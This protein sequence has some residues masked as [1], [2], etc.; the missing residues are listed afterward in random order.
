M[1]L[2]KLLKYSMISIVV[3][4]IVYANEPQKLDTLT[5]TANKVEENLQ[6]VPQ[7]ITVLDVEEIN[8]KGIKTVEDIIAEIPNMT[9]SPDRGVKVNFRGLNASLFTENNPV[10]IYIDG[11]P[12]SHKYDFTASLQNAKR[13]E[14]LRGPQ[15]TLYG[16]DSIGGVINIVTKEPTNQT[17]GSVGLE[18][19]SN[20]YRRGTFNINTPIVENK[21][22][23]NLNGELTV[24][25]GWVTNT[26]K[27][28]DKAAKEDDKKLSASFYYKATDKL[29]T[30]LVL[31]SERNK[32]YGYKG[33]G[34][35]G[36]SGLNLFTRDKA[37]NI[38]LE[39]PMV[40][41]NKIDSQ[42]LSFKYEA[43]NYNF[44]SVTVHRK[45]DLDAIFDM[46]FTS[47]TVYDGTNGFNDAQ[48]DSYSQ[49]FRLSNKN[50]ET[51]RW[52]A[53]LYADT[54]ESKKNA[55]GRNTVFMG[56]S[57]GTLNSV[58]TIDSDTQAIFGQIMVP[59]DEKM[60]LTL[61]GR[62]QKI[63]KDINL[64]TTETASSLDVLLNSEKTWNTFL[65]KIALNYK[66][67]ENL[68]SFV[69]ISKGYLPGGFNLQATNS[70]KDDNLFKPQQS[71]NYEVG[72]KTVVDNFTFTAS[73]FRMNIKDIHV[74]RTN[75]LA[76]AFTDNADKAHSQGIEFDFR[77][78]PTD[79]LEISG[80]V[81]F[82]DAKYD[83]YNEGTTKLD[84][85]KIETTPSH[86][87]SLGIAYY[88]PTGV[89][90]R[91]DIRNQGSTH[92][93]DGKEKAFLKRD[94]FT[95]VDAKV[96]YKFSDWDIYTYVKNLTDEKYINTYESNSLFSYASF[97]APRFIGIGVKY[98]F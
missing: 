93:Y 26:V 36:S 89:Y 30:R 84:G 11:I 49:E 65:P 46:D 76:Q 31:K 94:S 74:I 38:R 55:Y 32:E 98:T 6:D 21:L 18:Y 57:A 82:V 70:N 9:T 10:V 87:A 45:T 53:G 42:S 41:K 2:Q 72:V 54:E 44:E 83:S 79:S 20:N 68:T 85:N 58:S 23:F 19:G 96:G 80:A 1:K 16:K 90:A 91:T 95:L 92:F 73:V 78:F 17:S 50:R 88:H 27:N 3:G 12:T 33:Y 63:K 37:E 48:T 75:A 64:R 34:V 28:D 69:S 71:I 60:E 22:F 77:Y 56:T 4:N 59:L 62:Y 97:G 35:V 66:V 8:E 61:G 67:N 25:D 13:V 14:V 15:G 24:D 5:V 81:G 43:D 52:V 40:Q 29:S 47:G 51:I 86:T 7:S 39:M